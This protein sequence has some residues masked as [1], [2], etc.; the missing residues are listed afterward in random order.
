MLYSQLIQA[1]GAYQDWLNAQNATEAGTMYDD[2]IKAYDAIKDALESGKIGT[3]K[4]KAAIEFLV[5]KSV[6]ENAVQQY[7]DT[8]KKYLTDDSKGVTNFLNDAV[9]AGLMEADLTLTGM[10][11]SLV[12][13]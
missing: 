7:V 5:P 2:A 8:L 3:Q 12:R 13:H 1:S 6:D 10:M 4:Y 11:R 9:K